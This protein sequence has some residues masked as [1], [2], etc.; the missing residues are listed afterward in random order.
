MRDRLFVEMD[1]QKWGIDIIIKRTTYWHWPKILTHF[2]YQHIHKQRLEIWLSVTKEKKCWSFDGWAEQIREFPVDFSDPSFNM[3]L[4]QHE[5]LHQNHQWK[6]VYQSAIAPDVPGT[7]DE[8]S[9]NVRQVFSL[10]I[11]STDL[12]TNCGK[13]EEGYCKHNITMLIPYL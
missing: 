10:Q 3:V 9:N 13:R 8:H 7:N 1:A 5:I 12:I 11:V 2:K 6:R 4:N